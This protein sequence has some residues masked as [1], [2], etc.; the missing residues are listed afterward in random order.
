[1]SLVTGT[2]VCIVEGGAWKLDRL[3]DEETQNL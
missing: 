2:W 3:E 1:V